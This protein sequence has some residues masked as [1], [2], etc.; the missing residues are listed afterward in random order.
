MLILVL[1]TVISFSSCSSD[2][3][4]TP[5]ELVG[6]WYYDNGHWE[7]TLTLRSNGTFSLDKESDFGSTGG[8]EGVYKVSGS[9]VTLIGA[10]WTLYSGGDFEEDDD[11]NISLT[12][13]DGRLSYSGGGYYTKR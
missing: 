12:Y 2:D 7:Y 4:D 8:A 3:D 6:T 9:K 13:S 10:S 11:Y 1:G 5:S